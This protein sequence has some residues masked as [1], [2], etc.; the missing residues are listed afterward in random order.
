MASQIA[1]AAYAGEGLC[2]RLPSIFQRNGTPKTSKLNSLN[3]LAKMRKQG[4]NIWLPIVGIT[5][6]LY[7]FNQENKKTY[8][9]QEVEGSSE[10]PL[11]IEASSDKQIE[12]MKWLSK[13]LDMSIIYPFMNLDDVYRAVFEVNG[14]EFKIEYSDLLMRI[15]LA[16]QNGGI[17][18]TG[19]KTT[20]FKAKNCNVLNPLNILKKPNISA[21]LL[22]KQAEFIRKSKADPELKDK[23]VLA[24]IPGPVTLAAN[25]YGKDDFVM[26]W[27]MDPEAA[28]QWIIYCRTVIEEI[29][30]E[31]VKAG[32]DT[33]CILEPSG[34]A[35]L[36]VDILNNF[37]IIDETNVITEKINKAGI[38]VVYHACGDNSRYLTKEG[39]SF[40]KLIFQGLSV[41]REIPAETIVGFWK[42]LDNNGRRV[43]IF[44]NTESANFNQLTIK[45]IIEEGRDVVN[46][47]LGEI[48]QEE[49]LVPTSS[50]EITVI[51]ES[52]MDTLIALRFSV[53]P[54]KLS[55]E[56]I[57]RYCKTAATQL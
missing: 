28:K 24:W 48:G 4:K 39:E 11:E 7:Y 25:I 31:L 16:G 3:G 1:Q 30:D 45:E 9:I 47:R 27:M 10:D 8:S 40:Y 17:K 43:V 34:P 2:L 12:V 56:D 32:A 49:S 19:L 22:R 33:I 15:N 53:N 51:P 41:D 20:L 42:S 18:E 54:H 5:A 55:F 21:S 35:L 37:N 13:K 6:I 38:P 29:A 14:L 23:K 50:C 26:L 52:G 36:N 44:G 57:V 46:G